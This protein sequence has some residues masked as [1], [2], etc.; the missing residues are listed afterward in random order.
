MTRPLLLCPHCQAVI[1]PTRML[2]LGV[3]SAPGECDHCQKQIEMVFTPPQSVRT[4]K[5]LDLADNIL[6]AAS[7]IPITW[8]FWSSSWA[9]IV[10]LS[11]LVSILVILITQHIKMQYL[12]THATFVAYQ[13]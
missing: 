12:R 5:R 10:F 13:E 9:F 1:S 6:V 11:F 3:G 4:Y 8:L 2:I 7:S